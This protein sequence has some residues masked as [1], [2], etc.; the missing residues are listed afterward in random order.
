[1]EE[2]INKVLAIISLDRVQEIK[3]LAKFHGM[4]NKN[5]ENKKKNYN[6][7]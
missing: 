3:N 6:N 7:I 1:M 5:K 2:I 4:K